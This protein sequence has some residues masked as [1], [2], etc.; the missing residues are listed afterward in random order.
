MTMGITDVDR[1]Y[2]SPEAWAKG[3]AIH[4]ALLAIKEHDVTT[5]GDLRKAIA[6]YPDDMPCEDAMGEAV[7]VTTGPKIVIS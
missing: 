7:L 6:G 4:P 3:E 1:I 2:P 5:V